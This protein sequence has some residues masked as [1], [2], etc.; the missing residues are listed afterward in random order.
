MSQSTALNR[1]GRIVQRLGVSLV[2]NDSEAIDW[3]QVAGIAM[4]VAGV[5][6]DQAN[7]DPGVRE[8]FVD[9][10]AHV[11]PLV[12]D[13][14]G[15]KVSPGSCAV[16]VFNRAEWIAVTVQNLQPLIEP[17]LAEILRALVKDRGPALHSRLARAAMAV[18]L[19]LFVG[20]L[21]GRVL[22]QYDTSF[23]EPGDRRPG[24]IYF[25]YP[26]IIAFRDRLGLD[27]ADFRNWLALHELTH[28]YEFEANPWLKG[29]LKDLITEHT[30]YVADNL[31]K[32]TG[33]PVSRRTILDAFLKAARSGRG[34]G[35]ISPNENPVLAK[36]QSL[37]SILEGYSEFVMDQAGDQIVAR[38]GAIAEL[39]KQARLARSRP[40]QLFE[41]LIGMEL[42]MQQ[43]R[44]GYDFI[45]QAHAAGGI[46]LVNQAW[47]D[48]KAL[49]TLTELG[50]PEL[51]ITRMTAAPALA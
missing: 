44:S 33:T 2:S 51:W 39:F 23:M 19:G 28:S 34:A 45:K 46:G 35:L 21:A 36:A 6:G 1:A 41:R 40:Q 26:N 32:A 13:F 14:T 43:Y 12:A 20:Y 22:G 3:P 38:P 27:E 49:P 11:S 15:L 10:V 25:I 8:Q 50:R 24:R 37:M 29:Y 9:S 42:K 17:M 31:A 5:E 48:R 18:E 4:E 16:V 47:Q 7:I 30:R